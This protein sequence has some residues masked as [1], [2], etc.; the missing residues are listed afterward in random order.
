MEVNNK[1]FL[2]RHG[3]T[4]FQKEKRN[5]IYS[6]EDYFFVEITDEGREKIKKQAEI[7]KTKNIDLIFCSTLLR[8]KQTAKI[9]SEVLG[10]DVIYDERLVD[11]KMGEFFGKPCSMYDQFFL[12]KKLGMKER[13]EGGENWND[14]LDRVLSLLKDIEKENTGKNILII[15]HGEPLWLLAAYIRGA[16][17]TDEFLATRKTEINNSYPH[18]GDLI[19]L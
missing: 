1:Y 2:L 14:I 4:I 6:K 10:K 17:T 16:R 13:P 12:E 11:M 19:E 5:L 3:Q 15:S 18:V 8:A 9:V 7:L